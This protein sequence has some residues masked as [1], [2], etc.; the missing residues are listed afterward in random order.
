MGGRKVEG[1][2]ACAVRENDGGRS[3]LRKLAGTEKQD[4][5]RARWRTS[6][7]G[8]SCFAAMGDDV[9]SR[10]R[11]GGGGSRITRKTKGGGTYK[12]I[13]SGVVGR[14]PPPR[15]VP[16]S[17]PAL[18]CCCSCPV[19]GQKRGAENGGPGWVGFSALL[20]RWNG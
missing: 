10:G 16:V 19:R 1:L 18:T 8:G 6:D 11:A 4:D 14:V 5:V 2:P 13:K 3:I 7:D 12:H 15:L 20:V 17:S 9:P